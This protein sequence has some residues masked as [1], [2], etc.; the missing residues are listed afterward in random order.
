MTTEIVLRYLHFIAI[1]TMIGTLSAELVLLKKRMTGSELG[2]LAMIDGL[3]GFAAILLVG[4]GLTLWL[5]SY[6]KPADFYTNNPV[7][8]AKLTIV[9]LVGILS[10]YPTVFFIQKRKVKDAQIEVPALVIWI[11]RAELILLAVVPML[12]GLMAKGVGY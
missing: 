5:G 6:G 1:F 7:F 11:V 3:Y 8:I 9:I 4:A 2:R 10:A 12:A